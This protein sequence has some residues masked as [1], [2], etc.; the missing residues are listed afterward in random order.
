MDRLTAEEMIEKII[1]ELPDIKLWELR[2]IKKIV[3][4]YVEKGE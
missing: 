3:Y 1:N 4:S 2:K